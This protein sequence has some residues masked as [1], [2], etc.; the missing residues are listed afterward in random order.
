MQTFKIGPDGWTRIKKKTL[1]R[2]VPIAL[3]TSSIGVALGMI[4]S[5]GA[6]VDISAFIPVFFL[7]P[8]ALGFGI[9]RGLKRQKA[10]MESYELTISDRL[11]CRE[12]LNTP[13]ISILVSEVVEIVKGHKGGFSIKGS[14]NNGTIIIP[15]YIENQEQLEA[16]L[17]QIHPITV[18]NNYS[19][20]QKFQF[21]LPVIFI[22]LWICVY[23][24]D[25]KIIVGIAGSL[26]TAFIIWSLAII[27]KNK[28]ID[29]KTKNR[30]W[31]ILLPLAS[32]I[33]STILKVF[34]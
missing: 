11:I 9:W 28:N 7:I 29:H 32:I 4:D 6:K 12:Q 33:I 34:S 18:K 20:L 31:F 15:L 16:T 30:F 26:A 13:D 22:G 21:L 25:N 8:V 23:A 24:V 5:K 19:L 14:R 1:L 2:V 10:L 27:Q 3:F 17:Q